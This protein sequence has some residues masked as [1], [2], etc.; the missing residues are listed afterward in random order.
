MIKL[1]KMNFD[2]RNM[3]QMHRN[4]GYFFYNETIFITKGYIL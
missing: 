1:K 2:K 4:F 3:N